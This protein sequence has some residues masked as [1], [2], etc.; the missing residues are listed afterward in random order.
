MG[1]NPLKV[2]PCPLSVGQF[3]FDNNVGR[4][5]RFLGHIHAQTAVS[6]GAAHASNVVGNGPT[7]ANGTVVPVY[8]HLRGRGRGFERRLFL[9]PEH[10]AGEQEVG[11]V[12]GRFGWIGGLAVE[13]AASVWWVSL[14]GWWEWEGRGLRGRGFGDGVCDL[15]AY[16]F[17]GDFAFGPGGGHGVVFL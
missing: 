16:A 9:A 7:R 1:K 15:H 4:V 14:G 13:D 6:C 11:G 17:E 8:G 2:T 10:V 3:I 12:D 5:P